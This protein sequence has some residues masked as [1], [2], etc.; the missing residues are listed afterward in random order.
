MTTIALIHGGG[1]SASSWQLVVAKLRELGHAPVAID[2]P[3]EDPQASWPEYAD[4][5]AASVRGCTDLVVVAHSLG[6]FTGP[7]VCARAP[8][9]QLILV[10]AMIPTPGALAGKYWRESGYGNV[11]FDDDTFYHDLSPAAVELAKRSERAQEGKPMQDPWPLSAWPEV[12]TRYLLAK[13]DRA[14][15]AAVS[16][17]LVRERLGIEADEIDTGHCVHLARPEELARRIHEYVVEP[18][19]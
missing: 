6:G 10:A 15:P 1:D 12:R 8:V 9:R 17:G 16:R 3:S 13:N 2:L 4:A 14:F 18:P 11:Q 19:A 5:V 7:L